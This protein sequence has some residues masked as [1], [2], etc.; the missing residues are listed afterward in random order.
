[1]P[2]RLV[3]WD[4][5]QIIA[6]KI[7]FILQFDAVWEGWESWLAPKTVLPFWELLNHRLWHKF[8]VFSQS[9]DHKHYHWNFKTSSKPLKI[10][11]NVV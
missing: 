6:S 9:I 4:L 3:S 5:E 10:C 7:T 2:G 1:M 8:L 11:E